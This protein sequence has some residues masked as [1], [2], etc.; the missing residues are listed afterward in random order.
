LS[1]AKEGPI[2][3]RQHLLVIVA[4]SVLGLFAA[5]KLI[6]DPLTAAWNARAKRITELRAQVTQG[7]TLVDR[8]RVIRS[9]WQ[10]MQNNTLTNNASAAEQ[11]FFQAL[12]RWR[13]DSRVNIVGT[14]PQWKS[15]ADDYSSYQC[16]VE[17]SGSLPALSKFL[18][19]VET[20]PMAL[21]L[22]TVELTARD[23]EGQQLS[24]GLQI[25][26]LVLTLAAR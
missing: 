19:D 25:S 3:N 23:K 15:D 7:K 1:G 24:L 2:K 20:E 6:I 18:F 8:A 21:K 13:Q 14:T 17:A 26:G 9:R 16:R 5:D 22:E 12:E 4:L 10:S 11:Q